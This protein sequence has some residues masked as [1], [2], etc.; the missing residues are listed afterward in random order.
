MSWKLTGKAKDITHG[1]SGEKLTSTQKLALL[2]LADYASDETLIAWPSMERLAHETLCSSRNMQMVVRQLEEHGLIEIEAVAGR[3]NRYFLKIEYAD[4]NTPNFRGENFSGV[5]HTSQGGEIAI[6]GGYE[7]AISPEPSGTANR[8]AKAARGKKSIRQTVKDWALPPNIPRDAW[9]EW[10]DY[11]MER[12]PKLTARTFKLSLKTLIELAD[13]GNDPAEVIYQSIER[14][15][16]GLFSV[17]ADS[18]RGG[19]AQHES[20]DLLG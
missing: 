20:S 4:K 5:K 6:S 3:S 8:T 17:K 14:G 9:H 7:T 19:G 12:T 2:I 11:R 15:W 18:G 13:K 10:I 1:F 16:Q